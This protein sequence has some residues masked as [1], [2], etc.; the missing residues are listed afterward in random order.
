MKEEIL[1]LQKGQLSL[2]TV[3]FKYLFG[4][5]YCNADKTTREPIIIRIV[6]QLHSHLAGKDPTFKSDR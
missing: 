3:L 2:V 4:R 5:R 6:F 1:K